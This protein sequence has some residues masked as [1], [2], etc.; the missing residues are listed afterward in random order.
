LYVHD[1]GYRPKTLEPS[2]DTVLYL[3]FGELPLSLL[4]SSTQFTEHIKQENTV[5]EDS[6]VCK[7]VL[8]I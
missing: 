8:V 3:F 5:K 2:H 6:A 7:F 1:F 4:D